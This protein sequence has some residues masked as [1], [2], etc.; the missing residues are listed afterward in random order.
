MVPAPALTAAPAITGAVL[1]SI[2]LA[3]SQP[4]R[5]EFPTISFPKIS[6]PKISLPK[7]E[8]DLPNFGKKD[9][10]KKPVARAPRQATGGVVRVRAARGVRSSGSMDAPTLADLQGKAAGNTIAAGDG[11]KRFPARRMPGANMDDWKK[12]ARDMAPKP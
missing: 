6:L 8:L 1:C 7:F 4:L 5:I 10:A 9:A 11:W 3:A 2:S 12:I